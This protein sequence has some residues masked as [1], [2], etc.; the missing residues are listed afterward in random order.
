MNRLSEKKYGIIWTLELAKNQHYQRGQILRTLSPSPPP[1]PPALTQPIPSNHHSI[2]ISAQIRP[3]FD[4]S[5]RK[6]QQNQHFSPSVYLPTFDGL[7][8]THPLSLQHSNSA[9]MGGGWFTFG[10]GL[11][12]EKTAQVV[13]LPSH[14]P[15]PRSPPFHPLSHRIPHRPFNS[16]PG[17]YPILRF[18]HT[19]RIY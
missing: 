3:G 19:N 12:E 8:Q 16:L 5:G 15:F 11:T 10:A 6:T 14:S 9:G 17:H 4:H 7:W 1:A 13:P 2:S 18:A